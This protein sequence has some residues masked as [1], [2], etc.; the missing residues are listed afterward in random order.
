[1]T[2]WSFETQAIHGGFDQDL[3]TGATNMPIVQSVSF[4]HQDPQELSDIFNG[5][6]FGYS[7]SRIS[8]PTVSYFE[9]HI[10]V[11]EKGLASVAVASGM[12]AIS[13]VFTAL[14]KPGDHAVVSESLFGGTYYLLKELEQS[15]GLSFSFVNFSDLQAIQTAILPNT[16]FLYAE[17]I[18]NPK[19]D[20]PDFQA[21]SQI[22]KANRIPLIADSTTVTSYLFEAKKFG[23]DIL[24]QSVTK[25]TG[26]HGNAIGGMITD[27]GTYS[28]KESLSPLINDLFQK[29]GHL[30]FIVRCK[31]LRSN[32]GLPLSP[33]NAF[34]L[35][36]G[37]DTLSLRMHK[38]CEN[39]EKISHHFLNHP[40]VAYVNYPGLAHH[41]QHTLCKMQY[42]H[43][44]GGL[45]TL[46]LGSKEAC[47]QFI[48]ALKLVKNLANLGDTKS[49]IIHPDSTIYRD[50]T[51]EE[52]DNAGAYHDLLR[53]SVGIEHADDIIQDFEKAL[54]TIKE[55]I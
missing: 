28:W 34:L 11:L 45:L 36:Q 5:K 2:S 12:G 40:K 8:N 17:T 15:H 51:R 50:L 37:M 47:F 53:V 52:K 42:K 25:W 46:R 1:M 35:N 48:K 23:V 24:V 33:F 49:L 54:S 20:V 41:P 39:A 32:L 26:G 9:N 43:Q 14:L 38:Q 19:L 22:A 27:L 16:K 4:A 7:Y 30:A 10:T 21:I 44:F 3:E 55:A 18:G 29:V 31:K 6:K 13:T